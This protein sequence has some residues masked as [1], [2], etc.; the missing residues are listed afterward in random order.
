MIVQGKTCEA[1][2][3]CP[4]KIKEN[5]M[6]DVSGKTKLYGIVADPIG[7]V[8]AP[9]MMRKVFE[10]R[11][12]D[13][14]LMPMHVAPKDL[15]AFTQALRGIQNFGGMVVTV[16]HK[17]T[18]GVLC[19]EITAAAR[20]VGAVNIVRRD[21]DGRLFGDI[22]DG[23]GFVAGLRLHGIAPKGKKI[24]LAGAGGAANAIAFAL[25]EAGATQLAVYNRSADKVRAMFARLAPVYPH[26]ELVLGTRDPR[27]Y[28][29]VVNATSLGM[30]SADP[31]PLD[32]SLLNAE[33]TVAEIIMA[34]ALTPLLAAAQAKGCRIQYGAPMLASQIELMA[35][36]MGAK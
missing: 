23:R 20:T 24:L 22:L 31:L 6:I 9:E 36:F 4:Q 33:Q 27:G 34:P 30:A 32:A 19:D 18:I 14:V 2:F 26:V 10:Q 17:T 8:K 1:A 35:D 25:A 7:Q 16:P 21:P 11:G 13:G 12:I 28:D 3:N 29:L 15:P 5:C